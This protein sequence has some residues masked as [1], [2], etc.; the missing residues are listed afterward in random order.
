MNKSAP[1][2]KWFN[3]CGH[4]Q[5]RISPDI[6]TMID[7][8]TGRA[9]LNPDFRKGQEVTIIGIPAPSPWRTAAGLKVCGPEHF[10]YDASYIPIEE[11]HRT[12]NI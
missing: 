10:G 4:F 5:N 11:R 6:I 9:V 7:N 8:A 3:R 12:G 2:F 1:V